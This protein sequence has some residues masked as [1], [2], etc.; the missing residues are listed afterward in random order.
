[1][2]SEECVCNSTSHEQEYPLQLSYS[3]SFYIPCSGFLE[4]KEGVLCP[5]NEIPCVD[6]NI[7]LL[8]FVISNQCERMVLVNLDILWYCLC[9]KKPF[10]VRSK[11]IWDCFTI[12]LVVWW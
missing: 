2:I 7:L 12:G 10:V 6:G 3:E 8:Q 1:M 11:I 5:L 9:I 4:K